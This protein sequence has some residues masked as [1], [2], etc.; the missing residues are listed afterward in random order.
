MIISTSFASV[1]LGGH[2]GAD[3]VPV[4][5][6]GDAIGDL[7]DL[8][9]VVRDE[10]H[11]ARPSQTISRTSANSWSVPVL[12]RNTVGSSRIRSPLPRVVAR[13][14]RML[15]TART[16]ASSARSTGRQVADASRLGID[17]DTP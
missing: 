17:R 7:R 11:A 12:G 6:H 13:P 15:S 14:R 9:E 10:E 1:R 3:D 5:Q 8:V 4:A 2:D 16:I